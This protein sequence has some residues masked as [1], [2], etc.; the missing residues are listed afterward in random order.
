[1]LWSV[2]SQCY[3]NFSTCIRDDT[4]VY[5]QINKSSHS[6]DLQKL[7]QSACY[8][9]GGNNLRIE[10]EFDYPVTDIKES[11]VSGA[12][13]D[14]VGNTVGYTYTYC[15]EDDSTLEPVSDSDSPDSFG[16]VYSIGHANAGHAPNMTYVYFGMS[17]AENENQK[18]KDS[19]TGRYSR[20]NT[21]VFSDAVIN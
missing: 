16:S 20:S 14:R 10:V 7:A 5:A 11:K 3:N 1:M 19:Y 17:Y 4:K 2:C 15:L 9:E 13:T 12:I 21:Q 8:Y 18:N 6:C